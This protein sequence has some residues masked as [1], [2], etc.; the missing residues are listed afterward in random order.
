MR[1]L[2]ILVL[3]AVLGT[4]VLA[5]C[6]TKEV[7][8][9]KVVK[10]TVIVEGTPRVVEVEVTKVVKETVEV[11]VTATPEPVD[12]RGTFRTAHPVGWG[13][14]E[15]FDPL[16]PVRWDPIIQFIYDRL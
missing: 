15:S 1:T 6:E 3:L 13:G 2:R 11:V 7:E 8:V 4:L 5:A 14:K 12:E 10:E 16:S 9:T